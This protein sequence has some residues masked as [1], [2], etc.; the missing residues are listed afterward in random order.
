MKIDF[1]EFQSEI[2]ALK[3][4]GLS[5]TESKIYLILMKRGSSTIWDISQESGIYR[6]NVYNALNRLTDKGLVSSIEKNKKRFFEGV[7]PKILLRLVEKKRAAAEGLIPRLNVLKEFSDENKAQIYNGTKAFME[8]LYNFLEYKEPILVYG[9]PKTAPKI[10]KTYITKFHKKRI[11]RKIKMLHI[12]NHN[13]QDRIK[14]LNSMTF[15]K[16]RWLP[17]KLDSKVSTNICG[18]EVVLSLWEKH[19]WSVRIV[20]KDIA[21]AYKK[22]FY[23]LWDLAKKE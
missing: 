6:S 14:F 2:R 20:N 5:E 3:E 23:L 13:A 16:A 1:D 4:L 21:E 22:Y 12:Y 19:V 15:T 10:L 7:N 17:T 11:A 8:L 18:K 9:I